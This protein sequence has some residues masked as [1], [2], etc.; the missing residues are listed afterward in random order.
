MLEDRTLL[1]A[2]VLFGLGELQILTD[3]DETVTIRE[4]PTVPG[5]VDVQIGTASTAA[6]SAASLPTVSAN[7]V[8]SIVIITGSGENTIDLSGVTAG[9]FSGLPTINVQSGDGNDV[10]IGSPDLAM[11]AAGQDGNDTITGSMNGDTLSGGDGDDS[12]I[13]LAGNDDI[14]GGDGDD[15]VTGDDGDDTVLAMDGN[16]TVTGGLGNDSIVG[17]DGLDSLSGNE[18]DDTLNGNSGDDTITGDDGMDLIY[19]GAGNDLVN[20]GNDSDTIFGN[21]G[22]DSLFSDAGDDFVDGGS[23]ADSIEGGTGNDTLNGMAGPDTIVGRDGNDSIRGG[24][25]GD[26]LFGDSAGTIVADFGNDTIDGQGGDDTIL[27]GVGE[28]LLLGGIGNDLIQSGDSNFVNPPQITIGDAISGPE[29]NAENIF[30]NTPNSVSS[31]LSF[32]DDVKVA[33]LDGDGDLDIIAGDGT[34]VSVMLNS[35]QGAFSAGVLY[36]AGVS[37]F[38]ELALGDFDNDGDLDVVTSS[39]FGT[40]LGLLMNQGDGTFSAPMTITSTASLE[41]ETLNVGD[42]N[43]DGFID[44]VVVAST[45]VNPSV[46]IFVNTGGTGFTQTTAGTVGGFQSIADLTVADFNNDGALDV[47]VIDDFINDSVT[48]LINNGQGALTAISTTTLGG[49]FPFRIHSGDLDGDGDVDVAVSDRSNNL[50]TV[51]TNNGNGT[52]IV[53]QTLNTGAFSQSDFVI[54]DF[55]GDGSN[56]I[57]TID[58]SVFPD[59]TLVFLNDGTG[60]FTAVRFPIGN[61]FS[62]F[63]DEFAAGDMDGDGDLDFVTGG[64]FQSVDVFLNNPLPAPVLNFPVRLSQAATVPITVDFRTVQNTALDGTDYIGQTGTVTFLPGET[65]QTIQIQAIGDTL[66]EQDEV[67]FVE[68]TNATGSGVI[69]DRQAQGLISDDDGGTPLPTLSINSQVLPVEGDGVNTLV[70]LTVT[71]SAVSASTITAAFET[72]GLTAIS[73]VDFVAASGTITFLPGQTT[74]TITVEVV[75][76]RL[77]E[78]NETFAVNLLDATNATLFTSRGIITITNDDTGTVFAS[79]S[80]FGGAGN[81]TLLGS[82]GDDFLNGNSGNDSLSGMEG[83]DTLLGGSGNDTLSGGLGNDSLAGQGGNDVVSGDEGED[84]IIFGGTGDGQDTIDGGT[85]SDTVQVNGTGLADSY[86]VGQDALGLLTIRQATATLTLNPSSV[87]TVIVNGAAGDDTIQV[88]NLDRVGRIV[89]IV[90]G[91]AGSDTIDAGGADTGTVIVELNGD[92]GQD[93]ILGGLMSDRING[94]DGD[95]SITAGSGNDTVSGG[96][97]QDEV[98]GEDGDDLILGDGGNDT[99][100]G[101]DGNDVI[102]GGLDSDIITGGNGDDTLRGN[103]GDD[104][105]NGMAGNDSISGSSGQD[106]IAGGS[107]DD[108]L[109]GGR[110]DDRISGQSGNDLIRGNHGDDFITGDAGDDEIVGGD[111]N[112][113]IM[114]G[115]GSDGLAGNDGDDLI[116]GEGSEDTII[117]GDGNDTLRG[118]GSND[119]ILGEQGEDV[120]NGNSGTDLGSTGEGIDPAPISIEIIDESFMLDSN[121][122]MNVDGI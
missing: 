2:S 93:T 110:D 115:D 114:G 22:A 35:G 8:T 100:S 106:T 51:L 105:L 95:D 71:L 77:F 64:S 94:G 62:S 48:V 61:F 75:G 113:T 82:T 60:Q 79:D 10:I 7:A 4:N 76:D 23:G 56:D 14:D 9:V 40:T 59:D 36:P 81:D 37:F 80:L 32:P 109:D 96:E 119:T 63:N 122:M 31:G 29:S 16:D 89:L 88:E 91:G 26:L 57:L 68:L 50:I 27:G 86:V 49:T 118:G 69:S 28:D 87:Q 42:F 78:D 92:G 121:M 43:N 58:Q 41:G 21:S 6:T 5:R 54:G 19:A 101:D 98:F 47:A 117:G 104:A 18:G 46:F 12:I 83:N 97:G 13:G 33:D 30:F 90:N 24:S 70:T 17:G 39:F 112:D 99:L 55:N 3:A 65:L 20:G 67:F 66:A 84:I 53:S 45:I 72:G 11:S 15:V 73:D 44:I 1:A 85:G 111:G 102:D 52:M 116:D 34:Q 74:Q 107:G 108:T 103:F 38:E 120:I 25:D